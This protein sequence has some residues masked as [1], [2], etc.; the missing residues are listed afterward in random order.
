MS[1]IKIKED[2]KRQI[3]ME[4]KGIKMFETYTKKGLH[5]F[6]NYG[7][8]CQD[9][10]NLRK[11]VGWETWSEK[12]ISMAITNTLS[13]ILVKNEKGNTIGMGR[14]IG[15]GMYFYLQDIVVHP[16][17]Q[18]QGVGDYI[19]GYLISCVISCRAD[20]PMISIFCPETAKEF[21]E[22]KGFVLSKCYKDCGTYYF[23]YLSKTK[24]LGKKYR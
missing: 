11:S 7:I 12:A 17:F 24:N 22:R 13:I 23:G 5:I 10:N 21:Y 1:R 6:L 9:F 19:L 15:D 16:E 4:S 20:F 18:G 8:T 14:I 2:V 3:E